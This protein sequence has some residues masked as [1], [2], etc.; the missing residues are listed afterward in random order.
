MARKTCPTSKRAAIWQAHDY[1]CIYCT[2]HVVF[3]DLDIDHIIPEYLKEKPEQLSDLLKDY[4]L[5]DFDIDG[6]QNL[7]PSHRHCNLQK[8]GHIFR[9]VELFTFYL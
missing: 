8:R 6:L 4:E 3:A 2:E 9:K 7:V 1:R 5:D